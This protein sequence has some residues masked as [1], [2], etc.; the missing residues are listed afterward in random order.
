MKS[1]MAADRAPC[2]APAAAPPAARQ[3]H[4]NTHAGTFPGPKVTVLGEEDPRRRAYMEQ[5]QRWTKAFAGATAQAASW[6]DGQYAHSALFGTRG[7]LGGADGSS[8]SGEAAA[9]RAGAPS[10]TST[11]SRREV[12][13][14][15]AAAAAREQQRRAVEELEARRRDPPHEHGP[16]LRYDAG[17]PPSRRRQD[18]AQHAVSAG[19]SGNAALSV[20]RRAGRGGV[21][22]EQHSRGREHVLPAGAGKPHRSAIIGLQLPSPERA[23]VLWRTW[24][25][26]RS[27]MGAAAVVSFLAAVLT[28]IYLCNVCSCHQEMLRRNGRGQLC[29]RCT[30]LCSTSG[31]R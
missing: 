18:A 20:G 10:P 27:W 16:S 2:P 4:T 15:E 22:G 31:P 1:G 6:R 7:T 26:E 23:Q 9:Q 25:V 3:A 8:G 19:V 12:E 17:Q 14:E 21:R 24:A 13:E 11:G 29:R 28:E 30:R 5:C